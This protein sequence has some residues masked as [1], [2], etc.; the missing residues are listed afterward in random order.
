MLHA[1]HW[2][3][4]GNLEVNE[5]T[6]IDVIGILTH[7]DACLSRM[8]VRAVPT[9]DAIKSAVRAYYAR[10]A[11]EGACCDPARPDTRAVQCCEPQ[12]AEDAPVAAIPTFGCGTPFTPDLFRPGEVVV[13]L[14]SG[15]GRDALMAARAVGPAGR[16]IGVDMTPEMIARA[17]ATA[18]RAGVRNAEFRLGDLEALPVPDGSADVVISNCVPNLVPDKRRALN[19]IARILRPG[20]R[21]I[22][23]DIVARAPLSSAARGNLQAWSACVSGAI[24]PEEYAALL[25]GAGLTRVSIRADGQGVEADPTF[26]ARIEARKP[27]R[28]WGKLTRPRPR[29]SSSKRSAPAR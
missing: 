3:H 16:V 9:R 27:T 11:L 26:S 28:A 2:A 24:I 21:L 19:E 12:P 25:R 6:V 23:N 20:G 4:C 17:R 5:L 7:S 13:D 22:V 10:R 15:P 1:L 8:G 14:G 18:A 29:P